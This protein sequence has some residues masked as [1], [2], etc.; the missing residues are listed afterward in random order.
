VTIK[1]ELDVVQAYTTYSS[2][3]SLIANNGATNHNV[4]RNNL[5]W[6]SPTS[7][8]VYLPWNS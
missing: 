3:K 7:S 8:R 1:L 5:D 6:N 4:E 2:M